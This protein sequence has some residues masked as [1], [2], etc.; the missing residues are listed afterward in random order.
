MDMFYFIIL[1]YK[2]LFDDTIGSVYTPHVSACLCTM[3]AH[4]SAGDFTVAL[5]TGAETECLSLA[6]TLVMIGPSL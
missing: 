3:L 5:F 4:T 1:D 2:C 6:Q